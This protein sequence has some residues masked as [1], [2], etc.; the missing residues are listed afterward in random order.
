M[1]IRCTIC[2]APNETE[3]GFETAYCLTCGSQFDINDAT[4]YHFSR[5]MLASLD[6]DTLVQ[7]AKEAYYVHK[8]NPEVL[9]LLKAAAP[10]GDVEVHYLIGLHY[11]NNKDYAQALPYLFVAA[12]HM[13]PDGLCL[14]AVSKYLQNPDDTEAYPRIRKYLTTAN[15][16]FSKIYHKID[17]DKL[18]AH[19]N[20]VLGIS[21]A[22]Q[23]T[24]DLSQ[25]TVF[26][27][28]H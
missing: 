16:T 27:S 3:A 9:A 28:I 7:I 26:P 5:D 11:F 18:L 12:E 15:E 25:T 4:A 6:P 23:D 22:H 2:G 17:G 20:S 13:Y 1:K 21:T 24:P 14:Y 19:I 8:M 10:T